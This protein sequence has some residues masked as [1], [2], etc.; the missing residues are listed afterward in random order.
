[1]R[2]V[3]QILLVAGLITA[4][5]ADKQGTIMVPKTLGEQSIQAG[6]R[7]FGKKS[8]RD[9]A[10]YKSALNELLQNGYVAAVGHEGSIYELTHEGWQLADSL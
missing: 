10:A 6:N 9:Y 3:Y 5:A 1:M 4:A 2:P 8:K 7:S